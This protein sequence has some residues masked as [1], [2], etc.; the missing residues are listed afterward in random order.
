MATLPLL[1]IFSVAF[2]GLTEGVGVLPDGPLNATVNG[3]VMFTTS[4]SP[5]QTPFTSV[6]WTFGVTN[7]IT[8]SSGSNIIPPEYEDRIT[9]FPSTGSLELRNLTEADSGEYSVHILPAGEAAL[10]G[11]T[12]LN[13]YEPVSSVTV[14][15]KSADLVEFNDSVSLSCTSFGSPTSF[16]WLNDTSE[17]TASDRVQFTDGGSVMTIVNVTRFDQQQLRCRASNP[18]SHA[19]SEPVPISVSFGPENT[20]LMLSPQEENFAVGSNIR[21]VCSAESRPDAQFMWFLDGDKLDHTERELSLTN[22]QMNQAGNYSCQTFNV[23]TLRYQTSQPAAISVMEKISGP[24]IKSSTNLTVE[25]TRVDLTCEAS[26]SIFTRTWKKDGSDLVLG[27]NMMLS[28]NN[29]LLSFNPVNRKDSGEYSCHISNPVSSGEAKYN[30]VVNY[31]PDSVQIAGVSRLNVKST[32]TLSCSADSI[33][34]AS[35]TW[36]LNGTTMVTNSAEY[37]KE[38]VDFSDSG[39]YTC[40]ARNAITERT[41]QAVHALTVTAGT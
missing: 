28:D 32:L 14:D 10:V 9:L 16:L 20:N 37:I 36:K 31:G 30:M 8:S 38:N 1:L 7:I 27:D 2:T 26:G 18:V 21:L 22:I 12:T 24:S 17:V 23:K 6:S 35:Y 5:T 41:L 40:E 13:I 4:L 34:S 15:P 39:E 11:R 3:T 29:R 25:E 19:T 33:P